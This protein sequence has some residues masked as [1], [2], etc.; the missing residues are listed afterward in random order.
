MTTPFEIERDDHIATLWL[1]NPERRN[2]MGPAF[3]RELP[4][5]I[6][7]LDADT[8]VRAVVIAGR[9]PHFSTGLD[10][11]RMGAE[12]GPA[13]LD[14][15]LAKE[16]RSLLAKIRE[17]RSG[18][19][20]IVKSNKPFVAVLH[21]YAIGGGLDLAASCDVRVA[22]ETLKCGVR[23]TRIAMVADMGSL[24]RLERVIGRGHL[25]ELAFTGR[26]I[27]ALRA[28]EIGLVND[29][30]ETD[31]KALDAGRALAR[32]IAANSPLAVQGTKEV[33][34]IGANHG[35]EVALEYVATWN[36]AMLASADLR[37]AMTAF[38]EKRSP[39]FKGE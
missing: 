22:S 19:D 14:G 5:K 30:Y 1:S 3:W 2:A 17:M 15:G 11:V 28:K 34:R 8:N 25:R 37:E 39:V 18:F 26:D 36:A 13:L 24:Q 32:E 10:L 23:E 33:L 7:E 4:G 31:E 9:G 20:A 6:A 38:M 35:E 27:T 16:R 21:G 12:L 29:V